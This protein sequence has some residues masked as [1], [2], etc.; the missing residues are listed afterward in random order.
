MDGYP[1]AGQVVRHYRL[2]KQWSPADLG[3]ALGKTARWVPAMEYD[4][5][6]PEA[7]SRR[8]AIAA[9]LGIPPMLLGLASVEV[10]NQVQQVVN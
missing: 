2:L 10:A 1:N 3:E 7:I 5:T 6:V 8:R 4:N 9:I